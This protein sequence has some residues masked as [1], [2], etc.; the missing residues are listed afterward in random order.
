MKVNSTKPIIEHKRLARS[1]RKNKH[2]IDKLL[3]KYFDRVDLEK[4]TLRKKRDTLDS[5]ESIMENI[6]DQL[7]GLQVSI[8][9]A[10]LV[11]D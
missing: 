2:S 6:K 9:R 11:N 10:R 4:I 7:S 8:N 3:Q 5:V 1:A